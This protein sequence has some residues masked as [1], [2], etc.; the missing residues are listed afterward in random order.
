MI[1]L[2]LLFVAN[3]RSADVIGKN[4][5]CVSQDKVVEEQSLMW[6]PARYLPFSVRN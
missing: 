2:T 6:R 3:D 1:V 4:R 5:Q